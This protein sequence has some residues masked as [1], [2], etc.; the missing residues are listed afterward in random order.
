MRQIECNQLHSKLQ[1]LIVHL[2]WRICEKFIWR[3]RTNIIMSYVKYILS[4]YYRN[5]NSILGFNLQLWWHVQKPI[6]CIRDAETIVVKEDVIDWLLPVVPQFAMVQVVFALMGTWWILSEIVFL[7]HHVV[8][9]NIELNCY[10]FLNNHIIT[11][12]LYSFYD[13]FEGKSNLFWMWRW[14]LSKNMWQV[15]RDRLCSN[16]QYCSMHLHWWIRE[17]LKRRLRTDF[18]MS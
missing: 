4:I 15:E 5:C 12:L 18:I 16:M 13:V 3:L 7:Y 10:F 11:H 1:Y 2:Y 9:K 17:K 6:K 8:S 14:R